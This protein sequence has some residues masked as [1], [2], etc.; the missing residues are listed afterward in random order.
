MND[1]LLSISESSKK[2]HDLVDR[3]A[4][5]DANVLITG[6][7]GVGK[8]M[9]AH[10]IHERS[11]RARGPFIEINC[12]A[13]PQSLIE[14]ELFGYERGSFTGALKEGKVGLIETAAGGTL[15][16][17]EVSEIPMD[18]QVKL[19]QVIQDKKITKVGGTT[20][21][22]VDFRL[23]TASNKNLRSLIAENKFRE[24]LFYRMNVVPIKIAPLRKRQEEIIPLVEF[25][26]EKA[27]TKY[28]FNKSL[29]P[30]TYDWIEDYEWPGNVRELEN[31]IERILLITKKERI[32]L[33]EIFRYYQFDEEE[34]LSEEESLK[35]AMERFEGELVRRAYYKYHTSTATAKALGISQ[36]SA[37]RKIQKYCS[38]LHK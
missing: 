16:I 24:D 25:F 14:S 11:K 35:T 18:V 32:D 38:E 36:S 23:I 30:D 5:Y 31:I 13:I 10:I 33:E 29:D 2:I 6:E 9:Y 7:S 3:I 4:P 26:V 20:S 19:L 37:A 17:D 34:S 12:S 22:D 27:N 15:F 21:I 1:F 28:G 8:S